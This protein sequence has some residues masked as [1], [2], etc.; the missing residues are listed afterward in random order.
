MNRR[1]FLELSLITIG[2][3][4]SY[5]QLFAKEKMESKLS[6]KIKEEFEKCLI[7]NIILCSYT[8]PN[9]TDYYF[10]NPHAHF[11]IPEDK[12]ELEQIL[13]AIIQN[14]DSTSI[15]DW[16]TNVKDCL[17][18]HQFKKILKENKIKGYDIIDKGLITL[19]QT[20]DKQSII[21]PSQEIRTKQE[22]H[23]T[24]QF[25]SI[26][27]KDFLDANQVISLIKAQ[28]GISILEHPGTKDHPILEYWFTNIKKREFAKK[29]IVPKV[30]AVETFNSMNT[31]YMFLSNAIAK[32]FL[33]EY[34]SITENKK[35]GIAGSDMHYSLSKMDRAGIYLPKIDFLK[36]TDKD[37]IQ[38]KKEALK[39][40]VKT[41]EHYRDAPRFLY[42]MLPSK[43]KEMF[44]K[45]GTF[46][47]ISALNQ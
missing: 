24:S 46:S 40:R 15:T 9:Y 26:P 7:D 43:F 17:S 2:S 8:R 18:Y 10:D 34:N 11:K 5:N 45:K 1:K 35:Y 6:E 38:A 30:N 4:L 23:I 31:L 33:E 32:E 28:N 25:Y 3:I 21:Y 19:I 16:S 27:I 13:Q 29:E 22:F 47:N 36:F 37:I 42:E 12:Q 39:L 20:N 14:I 44:G 41:F